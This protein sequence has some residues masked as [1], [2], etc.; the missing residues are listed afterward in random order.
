MILAEA[1][2]DKQSENI[3]LKRRESLA[4][5]EAAGIVMEH[6]TQNDMTPDADGR[7]LL[8]AADDIFLITAGKSGWLERLYSNVGLLFIHLLL[9]K[10][11]ASWRGLP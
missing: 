8:S 2:P 3:S 4:Y 11:A 7:L 5:L 10:I 1:G 6:T 9:G